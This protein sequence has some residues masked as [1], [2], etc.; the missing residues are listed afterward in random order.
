MRHP[1]GIPASMVVFVLALAAGCGSNSNSTTSSDGGADG[2]VGVWTFSSGQI[3]PNCSGLQVSNFDLTGDT[4]TIEKVDTSHVQMVVNASG[5]QCNIAFALSGSTAQASQGQSC[6]A[7]FDGQTATITVKSWTLTEASGTLTSV[8]TG[9]A[10]V[11]VF[12][13]APTSTGT[14]VPGSSD[15]STGQ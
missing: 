12:T 15:A 5:L 4:V 9:S 8:M 11:S 1:V 2:F 13:C 7:T 10:S 6:T 14:L 3:V